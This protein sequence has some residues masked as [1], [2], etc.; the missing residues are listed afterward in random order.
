MKVD[1]VYVFGFNEASI[2]GEGWY[3]PE[4]LQ[5]G[6]VFRATSRRAR[7]ILAASSVEEVLIVCSARPMSTGEPLQAALIDQWQRSTPIVLT[8]DAWHLRRYLPPGPGVAVEYLD[9]VVQNPWSPG[10]VFG[11]RDPRLVGML[12]CTVRVSGSH[13]L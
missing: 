2:I 11:S 13:G 5:E 9:I 10:R 3:D 4:R 6:P 7:L 12:V 8:C 1:L